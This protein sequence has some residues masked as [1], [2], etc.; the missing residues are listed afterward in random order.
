MYVYAIY[1]RFRIGT[2]LSIRKHG[3]E[4]ITTL[5]LSSLMSPFSL[6]WPHEEA[7][8]DLIWSES[9]L[10]AHSI[11][12]FCHVMAHFRYLTGRRRLL[13]SGPAMGNQRRSPSVEGMR[14]GEQDILSPSRQGVSG[15][16]PLDNFKIEN[17]YGC[18][19]IA[20]CGCFGFIIAVNFIFSRK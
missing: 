11:C 14:G 3:Y 12:W 9:S 17:V 5:S 13:K 8:E 20:S 18:V 15:D 7:F 6:R 4:F 1:N 16:L 10:G 2:I 19:F